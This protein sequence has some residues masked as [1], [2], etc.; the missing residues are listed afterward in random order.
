MI[1]VGDV[2]VERVSSEKS[3]WSS[4][5]RIHPPIVFTIE[6]KMGSTYDMIAWSNVIVV[7]VV[8]VFVLNS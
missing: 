2:E 4:N 6:S 8:W 1:G 7:H 5:D 3:F